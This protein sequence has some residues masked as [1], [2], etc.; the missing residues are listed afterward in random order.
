MSVNER[1]YYICCHAVWYV[2]FVLYCIVLLFSWTNKKNKKKKLLHMQW[3]PLR[4]RPCWDTERARLWSCLRY[5]VVIIWYECMAP[6][7]QT[8]VFELMY[9]Y[10]LVRFGKTVI[11]WLIFKYLSCLPSKHFKFML[12]TGK[13]MDNVNQCSVHFVVYFCAKWCVK[14]IKFGTNVWLDILIYIRLRFYYNHKKRI[15]QHESW[16]LLELQFSP[17]PHNSDWLL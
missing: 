14:L 13:Y 8:I 10:Y 3:S 4:L 15:T 1:S 5:I 7:C 11:D 16:V 12:C 9:W 17:S 6:I 2:F